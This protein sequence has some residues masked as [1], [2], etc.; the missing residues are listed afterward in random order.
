MN[1]VKKTV[2]SLDDEKVLFENVN[3]YVKN[4]Q[5]KWGHV[6]VNKDL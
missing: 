4:T 5:M 1:K 2:V 6:G 3:F